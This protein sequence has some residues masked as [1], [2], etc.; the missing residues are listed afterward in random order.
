MRCASRRDR[1]A[2][3]ER[4]WRRRARPAAVG[5]EGAA[6]ASCSACCSSRRAGSQRALAVAATSTAVEYYHG[7]YGHYFVT[8]SPQEI[9]ALDTG[10]LRRL[11]PHRGVVRRVRRST[12]PARPTSAASGAGRRSPRRARTST[13]PVASECAIVKGNPDWQFEGEVFAMTLPDA[14]GACAGGTV[15]L[16]RLY[17]DGQSGAPNHRYTTSIAIRSQMLAQ[18]W[19]A[20]GSGIG[21]IGCVP[22]PA[23]PVT[24]VAAGDIGQCYGAPAAASGAARTAAL[25]TP[26]DALVLTLGDHAYDNGT[27]AEFA[28]CFH[29]TWGA[30]K[31]RIR[32]S[33]GN[34]DYYTP[35]RRRLLRLFRRAGGPGSPR[36]LQLRPS[37]AGISSRSTAS[38]TSPPSRS[39]TV[40]LKSDLA[41]IQRQPVHDR[42]LALSGVQLGRDATAASWRCGRSSTRCTPPAWR[43]CCR[44]TSTSTSGSRRR[45]PMAPRIPR[46]AS[47]SSSSAPAATS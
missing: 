44:G 47:A 4:P 41:Q 26:Q 37:G 40:W 19:I 35:G 36:L 1:R 12:P 31:D 39:S 17:N 20:E 46:V 5:R 15:P 11:E 34:H 33:P 21:V 6:C 42:L 24:I 43:S 8:A 13:R 2:G 14:A 22:V 10:A 9:A 29:P 32:P 28:N 18:G 7:G 45:R 30:F 3:T 38:S 27:P 16:Y 25:V 23:T